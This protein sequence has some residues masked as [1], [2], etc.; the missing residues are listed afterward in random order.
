MR[1]SGSRLFVSAREILFL[2][3]PEVVLWRSLEATGEPSV[4]HALAHKWR[5]AAVATPDPMKDCSGA[6]LPGKSARREFER[7]VAAGGSK[8][9]N[10]DKA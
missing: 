1:S 10:F 6:R 2:A 8:M 5:S 3:N 9:A 7:R 4:A